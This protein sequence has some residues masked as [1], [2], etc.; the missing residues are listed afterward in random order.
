MILELVALMIFWLNALPPSPS[1]GGDLIPRQIITGLT[2]DY[3]KHCRLQFGKYAQVHKSQDNIMEERTTG[4]I[5]LRSTGNTQEA[6]FFMSLR[7]GRRLNR[8]RFTPLS[9]PQDVINVVHPLARHNPRGLD[10]QDRDRRPFLEP[11]D[12]IDNEDD[13]STHA[14][15]DKDNSKNSN[16]SNKNER[17]DDKNSNNTNF[18]PPPNQ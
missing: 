9:L 10:I 6:Y 3:T 5:A 15:S 18:I 7:T 16:E 11:E 14:L 13:Y 4:A 12:R 1:V 8:Q 17:D 2:I